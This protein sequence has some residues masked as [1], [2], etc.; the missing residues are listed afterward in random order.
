MSTFVESAM[1][2]SLPI[3]EAIYA[4]LFLNTGT[5]FKLTK[6]NKI[7]STG[8]PLLTLFF[9][10]LEKQPCKQKTVSGGVI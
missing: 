3:L 7:L 10:T 8:G 4:K 1:P 2:H 6:K 9:E 5:V